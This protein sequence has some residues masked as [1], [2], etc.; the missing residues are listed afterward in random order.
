MSLSLLSP[1][2]F[3]LTPA[4]IFLFLA[5]SEV[6]LAKLSW[7]MIGAQDLIGIH[8][9]SISQLEMA[10]SNEKYFS[11]FA[12]RF[13]HRMFDKTGFCFVTGHNLSQYPFPLK[14]GKWSLELS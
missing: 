11:F 4:M 12:S 9:L 7:E 10:S 14:T 6:S 8:T 2:T 5:R 3:S 13:G 1:H